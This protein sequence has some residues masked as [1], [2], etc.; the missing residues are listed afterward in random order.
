MGLSPVPATY[1]SDIA[2]VSSKEFLDNEAVT[3]CIF[4]LNAH[5]TIKTHRKADGFKLRTLLYFS[6]FIL[7]TMEVVSP[8]SDCYRILI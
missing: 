6:F 8:I 1:I 7:Y 2:P 5:V 4:T 3:K